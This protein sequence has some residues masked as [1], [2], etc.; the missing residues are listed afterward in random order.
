MTNAM[1]QQ[2][3]T[4]VRM[5]QISH[6]R[7]A[8]RYDRL[9]KVLG[10]SVTVL[11]VI[12]GTSVFSA[13]SSNKNPWVLQMVGA[14]SVLA[15]VLSGI[16]TFLNYGQLATSHQTAANQ[17]GKLRRRIDETLQAADDRNDL[18][19]VRKSIRED[20]DDLEDKSPTVP[21]HFND[22]ARRLVLKED[23]HV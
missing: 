20:W 6:A 2:W 12:V 13:L 22:T 19:A 15:A 7:A 14:I 3:L 4:G 18:D 21:Q 17:Y 23:S 16:Q 5:L 9:H 1:L 10:V 8:A 11:S